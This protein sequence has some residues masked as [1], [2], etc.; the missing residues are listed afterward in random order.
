MNPE[1]SAS[2]RSHKGQQAGQAVPVDVGRLFDEFFQFASELERSLSTSGALQNQQE[3]QKHKDMQQ[4]S[5]TGGFLQRI[6]G[7][8][9]LTT[10]SK[11][12]KGDMDLFVQFASGP[13]Q[14]I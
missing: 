8:K 12:S 10:N 14:E 11:P 1:E 6:F 9:T 2:S 3:Q 5:V 13:S 4:A 7:K